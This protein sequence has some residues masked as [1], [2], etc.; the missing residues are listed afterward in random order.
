[1]HSGPVGDKGVAARHRPVRLRAALI[2]SLCAAALALWQNARAPSVEQPSVVR[3][4]LP[5]DRDRQPALPRKHFVDGVRIVDQHGRVAYSGRVE[6]QDTLER[7]VA[8]ERNAHRND[9]A[10]FQNRPSP[11]KSAPELPGRPPGYYH[12]YVHPTPGV[13][14]PGPQRIVLGEGGEWY[15][16]PDHYASFVRLD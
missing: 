5:R 15:Y 1:M 4:Q 2:A 13:S 16:T 3:T 12:E 6:L 8:G 7:I 10:V 11:G 9:G 14:G